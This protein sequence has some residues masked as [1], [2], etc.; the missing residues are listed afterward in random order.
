MWG[1]LLGGPC[2]GGGLLDLDFKE[3]CRAGVVD[4]M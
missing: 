1:Y 4:G 3:K 2:G